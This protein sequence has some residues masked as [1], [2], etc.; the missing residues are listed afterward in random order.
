MRPALQRLLQRPSSLEIL[1]YLVGTP[2]PCCSARH[3]RTYRYFCQVV[4]PRPSQNR[5]I[6]TTLAE[7]H[8]YD[9]TKHIAYKPN[10]SLT[11]LKV[12]L[13]E[14]LV[15][16]TPEASY[17]Y[18]TSLD[19]LQLDYGPLDERY[20]TREQIKLDADL[21]GNSGPKI[22]G[23][24][25]LRKDVR[26]WACLLNYSRRIHGP[27]AVR[28]Y[29]SAVLDGAF[30]L[31]VSGPFMDPIWS[32]FL[33]LGFQDEKVLIEIIKYADKLLATTGQRWP[34]LYI[35]IMQHMLL[36][37]RGKEEAGRWHDLLY[38]NHKPG[39]MPVCMLYQIVCRFASDMDALAHIY[40]KNDIRMAYHYI[41]PTLVE[42][43]DLFMAYKWHFYLVE[44]FGDLPSKVKDIMPLV[45]F[46]TLYY[47]DRAKRLTKS[48]VSTG[49]LY[50]SRLS[51]EEWNMS[52][53]SS[54][55][56]NTIHGETLG[57]KPKEYNDALGARWFAT[58]WVSLGLATAAIHALGIREIGPLSL[59]AIALRDTS[60]EVVMYHIN[61]LEGLGISIGTST[62]SKAVKHF[63]RREKQELLDGLL[64]SDQ[65]PDTFE[66]KALQDE[67]SE[68]YARSQDW[69]QYRRT[70]AI[71]K[72]RESA[73]VPEVDPGLLIIR[74]TVSTY[75]KSQ[76]LI[77]LRKMQASGVQIMPATVKFILSRVL[78]YRRRGRRPPPRIKSQPDDLMLAI[79]ILRGILESGDYVQPQFWREII[80]RLGMTGRF[81]ELSDL[82]MFLATSYGPPK[83]SVVFNPKETE[84]AS[85]QYRVSRALPSSHVLHPYRILFGGKFQAAAVEWGF[86]DGLRRRRASR[87]R[88]SDQAL[89]QITGGITLLL[90]LQEYG[91]SISLQALRRAIYNRLIIYYGPGKSSRLRNR[92]EK[93][94]N[95]LTLFQLN[96]QIRAVLRPEVFKPPE[97]R[98]IQM[99]AITRLKARRWRHQKYGRTRDQTLDE[100]PDVPL[101]SDGGRVR[102]FLSKPHE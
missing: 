51:A 36:S 71:K 58:R 25:T 78:R 87:A 21:L 35:H 14:T 64:N 8:A 24:P 12:P 101:I 69:S 23:H 4:V 39:P 98:L 38:T 48:L 43:E 27:E 100:I 86:I 65:H 22:I 52:K 34:R 91:V 84:R 32:T 56:I 19:D 94:R 42:N 62:F 46:M 9:D 57:I 16:G 26:L 5:H 31:P 53:L 83:F 82:C 3:A 79:S 55:I 47:P 96:L 68:S 49:A 70:E 30:E 10:R 66:D 80:R 50:A 76:I 102:W 59:Q 6:S 41:V 67:L 17:G 28:M 73:D 75:Y 63:A 95:P 29:W 97:L 88:L 15:K 72:I 45:Q 74:D 13:A 37:G 33:S 92:A 44:N 20:W 93:S 2:T 90:K 89:P 1:R 40:K 61:Q 7:Q 18:K 77:T 99:K 11:A 54:E 85:H 81:Q 60:A